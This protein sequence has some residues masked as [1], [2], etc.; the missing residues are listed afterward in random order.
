MN[1]NEQNQNTPTPIPSQEPMTSTPEADQAAMQ[2][3]E[4][5]ESADDSTPNTAAQPFVASPPPAETP[6]PTAQTEEW[7][8]PIANTVTT[9]TPVAP[10]TPV[11][12]EPSY[13]EVPPTS[14]D[15]VT[16]VAAG[17]GAAL[18]AAST[19]QATSTEQPHP[20]PGAKKPVNKVL[21]SLIALLIV[22]VVAAGVYFGWQYL[23]Q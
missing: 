1:P 4:A 11:P 7:T 16:P 21:V 14:A 22:A 13:S 3:I 15:P 6:T 18:G 10:V 9:P 17:V 8:A 19:N 12:S 20:F 5:L 2:A 23:Q